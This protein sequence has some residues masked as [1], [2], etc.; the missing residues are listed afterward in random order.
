MLS[1]YFHRDPLLSMF[2]SE[3]ASSHLIVLLLLMRPL[4]V[5][6]RR[7]W[8]LLFQVLHLLLLVLDYIPVVLAVPV[9]S[10]SVV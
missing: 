1:L 6:L 5:Y 8:P 7:R 2:L 4:S 9:A 10:T 3:S